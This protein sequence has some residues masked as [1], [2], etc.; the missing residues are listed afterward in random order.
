MNFKVRYMRVYWCR[1]LIK[2][3]RTYAINMSNFKFR[4]S[5]VVLTYFFYDP[6]VFWNPN[7]T[8]IQLSKSLPLSLNNNIWIILSSQMFVKRS[9]PQMEKK[10]A[11]GIV[12]LTR[13]RFGKRSQNSAL[14]LPQPQ[15][16]NHLRIV[17]WF[18][19]CYHNGK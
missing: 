3:T 2:C 8:N 7:K 5:P 9:S 6:L 11:S 19:L 4:N 15:V 18:V 12:S 14:H 16:K 10:M 13:P 1:Y 17:L